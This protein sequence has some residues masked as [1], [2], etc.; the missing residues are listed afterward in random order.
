MEIASNAIVCSPDNYDN[1]R[2]RLLYEQSNIQIDLKEIAW[3]GVHWIYL[4]Q[5]RDKLRD[6]VKT[7]MKFRFP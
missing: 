7:A 6:V 5:D 2:N 1:N 4:A 3:D